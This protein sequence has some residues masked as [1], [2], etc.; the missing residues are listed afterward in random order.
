MA[1]TVI[2]ACCLVNLCTASDLKS[3]IEPMGLTWYVPT[4][5]FDEALFTYVIDEDGKTT[6]Q[7]IDLNTWITV[8]VIQMCSVD[9]A[10]EAEKYVRLASDLDDGEA[11]ALAIASHR[12]WML[13]TDDRKAIR[14][15]KSLHVQVITTPELVKRWADGKPAETNE[16]REV[17]RNIQILA[18][19]VPRRAGP[20]YEWW[21]RSLE[22]ED[23]RC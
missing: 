5:V 16:L 17:L 8:G 22:A 1:E 9:D 10:A 4:A 11:M 2:D 19:F 21:T 3:M 15:A 7:P 20:L 12:G 13:A 18:S 14:L 6:A 23:P